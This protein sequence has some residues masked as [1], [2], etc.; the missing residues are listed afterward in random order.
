MRGVQFTYPGTDTPVLEGVDL[1][2]PAGASVAIVGENGAGKTTLVKLLTR[3]YRPTAGIV[4]VDGIDLSTI[5]AS[6]WRERV[7]ATF[8]D[9]VRYELEA[10]GTVGVGDVPRY[11]DMGAI[12]TAL[13]RAAA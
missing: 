3:M 7:A 2:I 12:A 10:A 5:D 9:F 1:T 11:D 13:D 6:A 4:S 8:Q